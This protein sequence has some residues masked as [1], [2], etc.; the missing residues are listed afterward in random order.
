M[1][2]S[3]MVKVLVRRLVRQQP[4]HHQG[5]TPSARHPLMMDVNGVVHP[6]SYIFFLLER[7]LGMTHRQLTKKP[8][9]IVR[10]GLQR[11]FG[12]EYS[13]D[14][15]G[16]GPWQIPADLNWSGASREVHLQGLDSGYSSN[17]MG[18][19]PMWIPITLLLRDAIDACSS[20]VPECD[21]NATTMEATFTRQ[22]PPW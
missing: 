5:N 8:I 20:P 16:D 14:S 12:K 7:S 21:I 19:G 4:L 10:R 9:N 15:E 13:S 17:S 3:K 2:Y 18:D 22:Y 11:K 6:T 1:Y